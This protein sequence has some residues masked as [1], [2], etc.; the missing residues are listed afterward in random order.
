MQKTFSKEHVVEILKN[1]LESHPSIQAAWIGGSTATG[2]EDDLSDTDI[3]AICEDPEVVFEQIE[4][5]LP[6]ISTVSHIWKVEE[7]PWKN[8]SQKF[9]VFDEGPETYYIDAG[10]FQSLKPEDYQEYF[11]VARHGEPVVL[12][13]KKGL[14]QEASKSPKYET[15]KKIDWKNWGARF[16]ILYRTFLKESEREKFIDSFLFYQ[17]LVMLWV[18]LQRHYRTPQKHDFGLRYVYRDFS[19]D[20]ALLIEKYLQGAD[21][22]TLRHQAAEIRRHVLKMQ[23]EQ[24]S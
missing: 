22:K 5:V 24:G 18:Q 2:F 11:N 1:S 17:R 10:V 13:D 19:K 8:F 14:L 20:E 15:P 4:K 16:E 21:L 3:V 12:F 6:V 9:Y 23:Q 7:S